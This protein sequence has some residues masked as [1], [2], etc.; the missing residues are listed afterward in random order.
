MRFRAWVIQHE[1]DHLVV[2]VFFDMVTF[3]SLTYLQ[4]FSRFWQQLPEP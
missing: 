4:V 3:E 2:K 1:Y